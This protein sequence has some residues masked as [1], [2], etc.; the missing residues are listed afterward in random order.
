MIKKRIEKLEKAIE[1][2]V[3]EEYYGEEALWAS[4]ER[5]YLL[6]RKKLEAADRRLK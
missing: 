5:L 3:P 2:I 6:I 4:L 1:R